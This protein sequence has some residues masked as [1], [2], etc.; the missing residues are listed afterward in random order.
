LISHFSGFVFF[1]LRRESST[2]KDCQLA[3][4]PVKLQGGGSQL[5]GGNSRTRGCGKYIPKPR[6][7]LRTLD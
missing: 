7:R 4:H 1:H 6:K 5:L 3:V 2:R